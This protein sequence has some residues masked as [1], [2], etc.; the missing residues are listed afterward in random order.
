ML[1]EF[2][3]TI[4]KELFAPFDLIESNLSAKLKFSLCET[5]YVPTFVAPVVTIFLI[6]S[7]AE[8][9]REMLSPL[10]NMISEESAPVDVSLF[11]PTTIIR[12]ELSLLS[13]IVVGEE[14]LNVNSI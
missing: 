5:R 14:F 6:V 12:L 11:A 1:E 3:W 4:L 2:S 10:F 9:H 7:L 13:T 8:P